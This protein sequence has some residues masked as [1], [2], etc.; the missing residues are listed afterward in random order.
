MIDAGNIIASGTP[1][2]IQKSDN[3]L[4]EKF[5]SCSGRLAK[6]VK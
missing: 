6:E 1:D 5:V 4:A 3:P 2:E